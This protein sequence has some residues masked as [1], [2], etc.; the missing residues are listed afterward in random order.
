LKSACPV[1]SINL[2]PAVT[3]TLFPANIDIRD[4]VK[5][6]EVMRQYNLGPN[7]AIM[8]S[9]NLFATKFDQVVTLLEKRRAA[10][11][12]Q[13]KYVLVDT[14]GQIEAFTWSASG[15]IV[16]D[17]L[18][19]TMP[20]VTIYVV[21]VPRSVANPSTFMANML[22]ACSI[23]YRTQLPLVLALTKT[24]VLSHETILRWMHDLDAFHDALRGDPSFAH[25]LTHSL[26]LVLEEFYR[27]LHTAGV[28]AVTGDGVDGLL[29]AIDSAADEYF[30][31]F[32]PDQQRRRAERRAE[33][34][35]RQQEQIRRLR[36]D[37]LR[38]RRSGN[39]VVDLAAGAQQQ[40]AGPKK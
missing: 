40:D 26:S 34:E 7:G 6:H 8:T 15:S 9:L 16:T 30:T 20:T 12:Q 36:A 17:T 27:G 18:A 37:L 39:V 33:E 28:S 21:D 22:Y 13:L 4:T 2:D 11:Q 29:A 3:Q 10:A 35:R 24:D 25:D 5:Y 38:D 14:P 1:Y 19:A 31:V 32:L 23:L